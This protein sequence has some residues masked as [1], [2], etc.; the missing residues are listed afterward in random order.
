[1]KR[2]SIGLSG[3]FIFSIRGPRVG[4]VLVGGVGAS[5]VELAFTN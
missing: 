4:V 3:A 1:M 2:A 5:G